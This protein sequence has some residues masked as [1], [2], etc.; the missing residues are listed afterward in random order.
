[1]AMD[2]QNRNLI[3]ATALSAL[4]I[5]VWL[6]FFSPEQPAPPPVETAATSQSEG[7]AA[8]SPAANQAAPTPTAA[9]QEA[10]TPAPSL[11]TSPEES[12]DIALAKTDRVAIETARLSGS[13]TL[14]G[15][16][17][18]DLALND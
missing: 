5:L 16:R 18:D 1:M 2:D 17:I 6:T 7:Q 15:G 9:G 14:K 8:V 12:R 3:L 13:L 11:T 10:A 4:V